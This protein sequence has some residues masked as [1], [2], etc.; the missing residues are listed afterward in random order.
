M[1]IV[2][3]IDERGR[4]YRVRLPDGAGDDEAPMGIPIGPPDVVDAVGLPE[5]LAT[6]LHNLLHQKGLFTAEIVR[7]QPQALQSALLAALKIDVHLLMDAYVRA[8]MEI[9]TSDDGRD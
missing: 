3:W 5:P 7:R 8:G 6:R 4:K 2:D 9:Y 1:R